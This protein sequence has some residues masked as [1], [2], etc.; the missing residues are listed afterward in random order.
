MD[1]HLGVSRSIVQVK[2]S[3]ELQQEIFQRD[4]YTCQ[5]CG[6]RS[7]KYQEV[8][9]RDGH[10]DNLSPENL[11]TTCFFCHQCFHLERVNAMGSGILIWMPEL[12]QSDLHHLA[13]SI[14]VARISQGVMAEMAKKTLEIIMHR[15]E[16]VKRRLGTDDPH[17]LATV[18]GEYMTDAT[19]AARHE[20]LD[21]VRL[22]PLDRRKIKEA[23][24]EFN[25]FP[26]IL[27]YWRSPQGPFQG[28]NPVEWLPRFKDVLLQAS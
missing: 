3:A 2:P 24:L 16:E 4:D 6:F 15:R 9:M 12:R 11:V 13:R 20:K 1:V 28:Y 14:Y 7:E 22:F 25:Q 10:S 8:L 26:Q 5:C 21:G 19:Y 27:A 23:D 18:L 17:V